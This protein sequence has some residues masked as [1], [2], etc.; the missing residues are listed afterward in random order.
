MHNFSFK[1]PILEPGVAELLAS[2]VDLQAERKMKP[3]RTKA[4]SAPQAGYI[5]LLALLR[6]LLLAIPSAL[7]SKF[8][9]DSPILPVVHQFYP[10]GIVVIKADRLHRPPHP[11]ATLVSRHQMRELS[12]DYMPSKTKFNP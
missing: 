7:T 6:V 2:A 5:D 12:I 1:I 11:A 3:I 10:Q 8:Q 9:D 4:S